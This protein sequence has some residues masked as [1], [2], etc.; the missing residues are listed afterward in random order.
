MLKSFFEYS[1][2]PEINL[3][4]EILFR[5][6]MRLQSEDFYEPFKEIY[7]SEPIFSIIKQYAIDN[8]NEYLAN[9]Q[10]VAS[11]YLSLFCQLSNF[12]EVLHE[13]EYRKSWDVLQNCLD[14]A[15]EIGQHTLLEN[16]YEVPQ[17][18]DLLTGYESLYPFKIFGSTEIVIGKSECSICGK[19]FQSLDCAHIRGRLYWGEVAYERITE[20]K[21]FQAVAMVR[22]P[23][24]KRCVMETSDDTRMEEE[25]Y[26]LLHE[27][28]KQNIPTFQL[29][30]IE[31]QKTVR[32]RTDIEMIGRN[33][34]CPC[35]SGKKF[36][37]CCGQNLYY[38]HYHNIIHPRELISFKMN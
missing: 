35:K 1:E 3:I 22:H 24:D 10:F 18:V 30:S 25:K 27:F 37:N 7:E 20:I 34:K 16:R 6:K 12:F 19:S 28:I 13:K 26:L 5:K 38:E 11:R 2:I 36:K 17:I 23:L 9:A 32:H 14:L 15:F 21:E 31:V 8:C 4:K 33:D 29:F